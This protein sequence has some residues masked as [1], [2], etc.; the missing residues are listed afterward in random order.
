MR[1]FL[2]RY[3]SVLVFSSFPLIYVSIFVWL[4]V[5]FCVVICV[6]ALIVLLCLFDFTQ[7]VD[8]HA[9]ED[10]FWDRFEASA[11]K[12]RELVFTDDDGGLRAKW[13]VALTFLSETEPPSNLSRDEPESALGK[14][15]SSSSWDSSSSSLAG[16]KLP[17]QEAPADSEA[18]TG[19]VT[20]RV[21]VTVCCVTGRRPGCVPRCV[22][23][24]P[25]L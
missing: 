8:Q 4:F 19:S 10:A 2:V 1:L 20:R 5:F 13:Q 3:F 6:I 21:T 17:E 23:R 24:G 11:A 7:S 25:R 18:A 22:L 9:M 16:F 15:V 12:L 14:S